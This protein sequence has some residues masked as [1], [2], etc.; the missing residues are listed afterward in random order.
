MSTGDGPQTPPTSC[1]EAIV[2][3]D[4]ASTLPGMLEEGSCEGKISTDACNSSAKQVEGGLNGN[5]P[6]L[7]VLS[8]A[9]DGLPSE[10]SPCHQVSNLGDTP[11]EKARGYDPNEH[12]YTRVNLNTVDDDSEADEPSY[13]TWPTTPSA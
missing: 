13:P 1:N 7:S 12:E 6:T 4:H 11:D 9:K 5:L 10:G 2:A 8:G 3:E